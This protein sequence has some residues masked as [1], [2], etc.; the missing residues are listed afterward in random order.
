MSTRFWCEAAWVDGD[1]A[2]GVLL[3]A[4]D[5]GTLTSVETGIDAAPSGA[6]V[7]PGFTLPGGVNAHSHA[8]H[9]ILRGRTHGDGGTFWTWREVMYSVAAKLSPES[10]ETVARAV[11]AEMLAG[12]YTSVG[13]FHYVHHAPDGTPYG[14]QDESGADAERPRG[15]VSAPAKSR[16]HAMERAL[17]RAAASAGIRIRLL[18]TCYLTGGIDTELSAEQARF[19]D[20]AID[21]YMDR[22]ADLTESF[23][24]EFPV[25]S[26]GESYVHVGAAIHSIRAVPAA[27]LPRF[28]ELDG[29]V[30]VHLSEQPA[31]NDA[32]QAAYG[33]TPT[34]VLARS[35]VVTAD[36]SA[37]H[38]THLSAEDIASLGGAGTSI[39]MCPCTEADLADGIGPARELADAGATIAIGSDQHVVLDAL[40]ETQGLE[41]GE[42]LRSGQRGRFSPAELIA[43]LTT[44]GARSLELPV[45]ELAV[46]KACDFVAL[47]TES[48]RTFGSVG[49]QII[50]TA[51]SADV[52]LTVSGGRVRVRDGLHTEL[53]EISELY[54]D[55]FAALGMAPGTS[56]E[57]EG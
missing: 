42:R 10:Y 27:N 51:T 11:F 20:G 36:L 7:V 17:A 34:Q 44:G 1:V 41:A 26:P 16:A 24:A 5:T 47:S 30:H 40:R 54:R 37:V 52:S 43:S 45:G 19:G 33:T 53:G 25:G 48:M 6:E 35:G 21:G 56:A 14:A 12:G 13:E 2:T 57:A 4:D 31:E 9:R 23:A 46:G 15:D 50:L 3:T 32:C 49:E 8:F 39:V 22:H 38:A 55:A 28:A 29:P 18:D